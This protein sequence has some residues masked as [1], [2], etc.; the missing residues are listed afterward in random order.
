MLVRDQNHF[1]PVQNA[2]FTSELTSGRKACSVPDL[3]IV[4]WVGAA[5]VTVQQGVQPPHLGVAAVP[6][7]DPT[8]E[9]LQLVPVARCLYSLV[10]H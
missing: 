2:I 6:G 7:T 8:E 9:F 5:A 10:V 4:L 1:H 3:F